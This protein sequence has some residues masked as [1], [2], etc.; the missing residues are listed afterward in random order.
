M[1]NEPMR[2]VLADDDEGDRTIFK[3]ALE[4]LKI[5][6]KV[7]TVND[8][9]ELMEYLALE[10]TP[11]PYM[12]FLDLNMPL[13]GGMQCLKEIKKIPRLREVAIAIYST[14]SSEENITET[15]HSGANVY[16]KKPDDFKVLKDVLDKVVRAAHIYREPP[17]NMANFLFKI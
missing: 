3:D 17:F 12:L 10:D 6:T 11:L 4:E 7:H 13:K 15:F 9:V 2:I 16:I 8:G 14:S 1:N 5:K